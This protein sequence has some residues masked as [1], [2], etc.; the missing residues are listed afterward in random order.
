MKPLFS[1]IRTKP[2]KEKK[3]RI[4]KNRQLFNLEQSLRELARRKEEKQSEEEVPTLESSLSGDMFS[5]KGGNLKGGCADGKCA[6]SDSG[7]SGVAMAEDEGPDSRRAAERLA[8]MILK[9]KKRKSARL[10]EREDRITKGWRQGFGSKERGYAMYRP[11]NR[12]RQRLI[13]TK[14]FRLSKRHPGA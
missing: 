3:Q 10:K 13:N 2:S 7:E 1:G 6:A 8:D 4:T 5:D 14:Q 12:L 9:A 11:L